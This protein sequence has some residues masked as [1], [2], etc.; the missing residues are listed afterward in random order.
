MENGSIIQKILNSP[1]GITTEGIP[2]ELFTLTNNNG[3]IAKITNYGATIVALYVPDKKGCLEDIVL[4]F[5]SVS[6]Y[7]K[8]TPQNPYFGAT[9]G[10]Y[11]NRIANGQF[12]LNGKT[13]TL[14]QNDGSNHLH[15]GLKGFQKHVFQAIPMLSPEGPSIRFKYLSHDGDEGYPGNLKASI[16][17][18]LTNN[19][20]LK[21]CYY[22][23]T[24][25]TTIINLTNHSYFNLAGEGNG[26][27]LEHKLLLEAD[28]Y[29]PVNASLIPTGEIK[30]VKDTPFDFTTSKIIGNQIEKLEGD[31]SK[32]FDHNFV[33]NKKQN[34]FGLAARVE[35]PI[36]GRIMEIYTTE[37]GLQ[38][39]TGN[40]VN[41]W[42]KEGKFYAKY[43]GFAVETQHFPDSPNKPNFPSTVLKPDEVYQSVTVYKFLIK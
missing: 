6:D 42:G 32:G 7:E 21:I 9:V 30:S 33:L 43:S 40:K 15:G 12:V 26:N 2:I 3:L 37:P 14:A 25:K 34:V 20:E 19:N 39:Y 22:A 31:S 29:T 35:E 8:F 36:S 16:T 24:D 11:A 17:Y 18:T 13:Y 4:G 10:R 1:W 38:F 41:T 27:I 28:N 23:T 5:D